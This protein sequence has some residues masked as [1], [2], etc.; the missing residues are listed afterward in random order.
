MNK[1]NLLLIALC[2]IGLLIIPRTGSARMVAMSDDRLNEVTGQA[3]IVN[4]VVR[5][6]FDTQYDNVPVLGQLIN[7]SDVSMYGSVINRIPTSVDSLTDQW[8]S[9]SLPG[10]GMAGLGLMGLSSLS[11]GTNLIDQTINIDRLSI[12]AIRIGNDMTGPSLGSIDVIGMQT[13]IKG[14]VTV[15]MH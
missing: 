12:G 6:A 7:L 3:G 8:V 11:L 10:L 4:D 5:I 14:I 1:K 9:P 13:D 2:I 15:T